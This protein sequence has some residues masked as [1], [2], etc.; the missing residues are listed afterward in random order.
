[1]EFGQVFFVRRGENFFALKIVLGPKSIIE[2]VIITEFN[3][4][5]LPMVH[6]FK[7]DSLSFYELL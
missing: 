5:P 3:L 2:V 1:M 4:S 6:F 7:E